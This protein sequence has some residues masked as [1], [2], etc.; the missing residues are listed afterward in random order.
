MQV[1]K[2]KPKMPPYVKHIVIDT[3]ACS[4]CL[5]C[6]L[7]CSARHFDGEC[8]P[9][10]SAIHID[11]DLLDYH[12]S[13]TVCQQCRTAS[14]AAV[15]PKGAIFFDEKTGARCIDSEKCIKCGACA[16]ACPLGALKYPPIRKVMHE[17]KPVM[18]KCDLCR[19]HEDGPYCVQVCPKSAISLK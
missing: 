5:T 6:E 13:A 4:G 10:L 12:F 1:Q 2:S 14:C 19:G 3:E 16:R 8:N 15:C 18:I 17:G 7:G 9:Q 11:A